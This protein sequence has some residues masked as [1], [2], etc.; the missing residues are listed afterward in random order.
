MM[1]MMMRMMLTVAVVMAKVGRM[2]VTPRMDS[3]VIGMFVL[4]NGQGEESIAGKVPVVWLCQESKRAE[5]R[6]KNNT[7]HEETWEWKNFVWTIIVSCFFST[8]S[9][10]YK[11][12]PHVVGRG[13]HFHSESWQW[14]IEV[15]SECIV[16]VRWLV[17][18]HRWWYHC[19]TGATRIA[20]VGR[21]VESQWRTIRVKLEWL[22]YCKYK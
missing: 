13:A 19:M 15:S 17:P 21:R 6:E 3:F 8:S 10:V 22:Q 2:W 4:E 18:W 11:Y 20:S 16:N 7:R 14:T 5:K 1:M 12:I 9:R